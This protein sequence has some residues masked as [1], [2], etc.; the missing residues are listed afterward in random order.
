MAYILSIET[1][2]TICSIAIHQDG[3]LLFHQ[4]MFL[5]QSHSSK[6]VPAIENALRTLELNSSDL[7]AVAISKGPGSYTGL[8]I[9]TSTAKGFCY[10][11]DIPLIAIN[12]LQ[13][14]AL[15]VASL[16][17]SKKMI[18]LLD[19]RRMEVFYEVFDENVQ[20]NEEAKP[21]ILEENSFENNLLSE[22]YLIFGN[23]MPKFKDICVNKNALFLNNIYPSAVQ[24]GELAWE[25][26]Q[27]QEF[28]DVA[29]FEPFYLKEFF[30][31]AKKLF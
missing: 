9:G 8:R 26:Y 16:G 10:A 28:E 22:S 23:G 2:T 27:K 4:E 21:L 20:S 25:K 19:A 18:P 29:Y 24:V 31:T 6:L 7:A 17:L 1:A 30:T 5:E 15:K 3:N 14:M 12:T 13:T 11:L